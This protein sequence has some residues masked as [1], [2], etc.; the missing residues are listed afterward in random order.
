MKVLIILMAATLVTF[1][2]GGYSQTRNFTFQLKGVNLLE[3]FEEIEQQSDMQI[4]YDISSIDAERRMDITVKRESVE[5]VLKEALHNTDLSYRIM[6]RY[7]IIS[8]KKNGIPGQAMQQELITVSG[9]VTDSDGA[10]LPGVT[11]VVEGTTNGT[12]SN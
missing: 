8:T 11:V 10:P 5:N 4:A 3:V 1:A 2:S 12:I 7:I 6:D 9:K